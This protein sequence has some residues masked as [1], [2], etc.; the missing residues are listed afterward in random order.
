MPDISYMCF[1]YS[2]LSFIRNE[3]IAQGIIDNATPTM[4]QNTTVLPSCSLSIKTCSVG[5]GT[6]VTLK[7][8]NGFPVTDFRIDS[9]INCGKNDVTS[10]DVKFTNEF[11]SNYFDLLS[12]LKTWYEP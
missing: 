3:I 2:I 4:K 11:T 10:C 6:V 7:I 12:A 1:N 8:K 5:Y 9:Y